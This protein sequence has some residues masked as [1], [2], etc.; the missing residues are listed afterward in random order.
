MCFLVP[1]CLYIVIIASANCVRLLVDSTNTPTPRDFSRPRHLN[2]WVNLPFN[3]S[4]FFYI[5]H[6][7]GVPGKAEKVLLGLGLV[8]ENTKIGLDGSIGWLSIMEK[9]WYLILLDY[10]IW[11]AG[12]PEAYKIL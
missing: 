2:Q 12:V 3:K 8:G 9:S 7:I 6:N 4:L 11:H 10:N 1:E 5:I